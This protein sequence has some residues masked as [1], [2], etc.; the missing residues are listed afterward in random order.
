MTRLIS[1][2]SPNSA[3]TIDVE[4]GINIAMRDHFQIM[5]P[6]T[7]RVVTNVEILLDLFDQH[8]TK[9]TFFIL[10]EVSEKFPGIVRK[11]ASK[12][13]E[14]GVHG[15]M[16]DQLY[17]ITPQKAKTDISKAKDIIENTIGQKVYGFRAP[18]FSIMPETS[19]AF[20][21]LS[22]LGF[23]YDSS[24]VPAKMGRYG[25]EGFEQQI[26]RLN[27]PGKI[28]LIEV[29]LPVINFFGRKS[30]VCGG[31]YLRYFPLLSTHL[32]F[33]HILK[34]QPVIM[35]LH[36]YE[37]DNERYPDY[38][39]DARKKIPLKKALPL[40]FYRY[41]KSSVKPKLSS[42]LSK[43]SFLPLIEIIETIEKNRGLKTMN[44][45]DIIRV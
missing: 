25:W 1:N 18:A 22:N 29:P 28:N 19:W 13:H 33:S 7:V 35:Y 45:E 34:R 8:N 38:F 24:I 14:V 12:G 5:M 10:G 20:E 9:A 4:D 41:K 2:N 23:K 26:I 36:P 3:I 15:Y 17:N 42:I 39:Y 16:H 43:Y 27:L 32:A 37:L 40:L 31:G 21:L 30:P 6:P 11:I 44:L